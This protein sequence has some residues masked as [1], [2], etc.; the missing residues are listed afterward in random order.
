MTQYSFFFLIR[1]ARSIMAQIVSSYYGEQFIYGQPLRF[2]L[3]NFKYLHTFNVFNVTLID[4]DYSSRQPDFFHSNTSSTNNAAHQVPLTTCI[5]SLVVYVLSRK[6]EPIEVAR[7][8]DDFLVNFRSRLEDMRPTEIEDYAD[9]LAK[10]LTKPIRKLGDEATIHMAKIRRYGPETLCEGT[11]YSVDDIPWDSPE[12]MKGALKSL[13]RDVILQAYDSL[14]MKKEVRSRITSFVYG[15]TFPLKDKKP[16]WVGCR[17]TALSLDEIMKKR[18]SLIAYD[19]STIYKKAGSNV[20]KMLEKHKISV[21]YAA[22]AAA[23]VGVGLWGM[24]ALKGRGEE[25]RL[26]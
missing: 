20:R 15:K 10:A 2:I 3:C 12:V 8:I 14:V 6:E 1:T 5:D 26:K 4:V 23:L 11:E 19:P 18:E 24:A 25:K 9:S 16:S 17:F 7:R 22:T 13:N 21:Q